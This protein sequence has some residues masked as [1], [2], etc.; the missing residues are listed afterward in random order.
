MAHRRRD[1]LNLPLLLSVKCL[2]RCRACSYGSAINGEGKHSRMAGNLIDILPADHLSGLF[3]GR[4]LS[5]A[6]PCVIAIRKGEVF[7]LTAEVAT[8]AGAVE[9]RAFGGGQRL[10]SVEDGLP[11]GWSLLSP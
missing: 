7:D 2:A 4:A 6:G 5:P 11:L 10:G 8:V 3:L 9:R 1:I